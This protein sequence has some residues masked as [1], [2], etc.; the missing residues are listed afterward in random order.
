[1]DPVGSDIQRL[2]EAAVRLFHGFGSSTARRVVLGLLAAGL[3]SVVAYALIL[4][5]G[6]LLTARKSLAKL[7]AAAAIARRTATGFIRTG[8]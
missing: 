3:A 4:I 2:G 8:P 6:M 5:P 1:M 7:G